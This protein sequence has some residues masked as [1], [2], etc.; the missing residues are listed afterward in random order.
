MVSVVWI[1]LLFSIIANGRSFKLKKSTVPL[2]IVLD[3]TIGDD[4]GL[5]PRRK[6]IFPMYNQTQLDRT[7]LMKLDVNTLSPD[8]PIFLDLP[9]PEEHGAHATAFANHLMWKRRLS[10]GDRKF[11]F[12]IVCLNSNSCGQGCVGSGGRFIEDIST[13]VSFNTT[14][15]IM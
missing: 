6:S 8:D 5:V 1:I 10:E 7:R 15:K 3:A 11:I 9:W 13:K 2:S 4:A 14:W 12:A